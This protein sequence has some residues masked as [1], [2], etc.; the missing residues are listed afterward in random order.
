[1]L[2][3]IRYLHNL[4]N[5]IVQIQVSSKVHAVYDFR[6]ISSLASDDSLK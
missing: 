5:F 2:I 6:E 4:E 3:K 1:M